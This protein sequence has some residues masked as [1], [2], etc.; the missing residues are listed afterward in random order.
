MFYYS[1]HINKYAVMAYF[2]ALVI[3]LFYTI[4]NLL[5]VS[6]NKSFA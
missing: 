2:I 5:L 6:L 4:S 1:H 3:M